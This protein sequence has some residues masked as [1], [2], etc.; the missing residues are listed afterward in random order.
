MKAPLPQEVLRRKRLGE[1][2]DAAAIR[3]AVDGIAGGGWSDAQVGAFAMAV[4]TRGMDA[5]ETRALTLAMRDSGACL[6]FD[7]LPG[8][9]VD[10]HSTGGIGDNVS[11]M[12]GPMLA[13]CGACVPMISG[14]GL[15]HTG[16]TLDKLE[17]IPGYRSEVD[18]A[19][20]QR[21]VREVGVAIVGASAELAPADRRLYA[22]RDV[23]ATVE[24]I[25][26]ITASI[27]AK[28]LAEQPRALILDVKRGTGAT[29]SD[30]AEALRLAGSL[31]SVA[32]QCGVRTRALLTDMNQAL[33]PAVGNTLELDVAIDYLQGRSRSARLHA[34]TLAL[35][36]ALLCDAGLADNPV[37][38]QASLLRALDSGAAWECFARMVHALGGDLHQPR[39][40]APHIRPLLA[41]RSG[42]LAVRDARMIGISVVTLGGGRSHPADRI[43]HRVGLDQLLAHGTAVEPR[44]PLLFIRAASADAADAAA[45]TLRSALEIVDVPPASTPLIEELDG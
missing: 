44:T 39:P 42:Y 28:K 36:A 22:V 17:A 27:L 13:A 40:D 43:D 41:E 15:G 20:L 6:S 38:A 34:V 35:G 24:S 29:I 11:L 32:R 4:C 33:A 5:A 23:T 19:T 7:D 25:P 3:A 16:G 9:V 31:V 45:R 18:L 12:L 21:I 14:R 30:A 2:L 8:P 10:K 26:L 1:A 37:A